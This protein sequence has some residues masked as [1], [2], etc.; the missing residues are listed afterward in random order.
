MS[1]W[2][3]IVAIGLLTFVT[4]LSFIF[5]FGRRGVPPRIRQ[6]LRF[7]PPA[8]LTALILPELLLPT[9]LVDISFGNERLIAGILASIVA[10]RTKNVI[11]TILVGMAAL[12]VLM[13]I[14]G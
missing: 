8:V 10:W 11:A 9:G 4:R 3:I 1:T 14:N 2:L 6:A 5:V 13:T 7:V 12:I